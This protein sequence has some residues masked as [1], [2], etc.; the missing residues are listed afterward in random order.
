VKYSGGDGDNGGGGG[1]GST[2][3]GEN[4]NGNASGAGGCEGGGAGGWMPVYN[5]ANNGQKAGGAGSGAYRTTNGGTVNGGDGSDGRVKMTYIEIPS[6]ILM[7]INYIDY[8]RAYRWFP[9]IGWAHQLIVR[10]SVQD[11]DGYPVPDAYI[12]AKIYRNNNYYRD[13]AGYVGL[14]TEFYLYPDP[15][16]NES[17]FY[18]TIVEKLEAA[19]YLWDGVTPNNGKNFTF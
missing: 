2:E 18:K 9:G 4:S 11:Y 14:A 5:G 10:M 15:P 3:D 17:G 6:A 16:F 7:K 8:D 12:T 13:L 1:A 19:G